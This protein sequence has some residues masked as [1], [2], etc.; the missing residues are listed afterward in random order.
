[1]H[2]ALLN[3]QG[4]EDQQAQ[5][6]RHHET[7]SDCGHVQPT[8]QKDDEILLENGSMGGKGVRGSTL[9]SEQME[10]DIAHTRTRS[11]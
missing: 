5:E 2:A 1:M 3:D 4:D 9:I 6:H 7:N 11:G 10:G 8:L